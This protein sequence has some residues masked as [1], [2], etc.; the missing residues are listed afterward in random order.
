[1]LKSKNYLND[2]VVYEDGSIFNKRLNRPILQQLNSDGYK[3]VT[4]RLGVNKRKTFRV[5]RIV[6]ELFLRGCEKKF[7]NH[8]DGV[9]VNNHYSNLEWMTHSENI[10][11]A[12]DNGLIKNTKERAKKIREAN[13]GRVGKLNGKS[14]P[15]QC[16]NTGEVFESINLAAKHYNI[17]FAGI[18]KCCSGNQKTAAKCLKTGKP[19]KWRYYE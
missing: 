13:L 19:L 18:S 12:W 10:K 9:K 8:K 4:L 1:M 15:V 16:I 11:H 2:Y 5:H 14:R 7:V 6:A 3:C 17:D